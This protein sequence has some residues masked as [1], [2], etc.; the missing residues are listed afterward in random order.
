MNEAIVRDFYAALNERRFDRVTAMIAPDCPTGMPGVAP[1]PVGYVAAVRS[2]LTGF[3]DL[4][5]KVLETIV[6]DHAVAVRVRTS[7]THLGAFLGHPA[8]G[9]RFV[10]DGVDWLRF[11]DGVISERI[12]VFD[13]VQML[14]QLELYR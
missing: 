12:G 3:P 14:H 8:T 10:A 13:T 6:D 2:Y 5:H 7:G 4:A 11:R 9:R 1:G